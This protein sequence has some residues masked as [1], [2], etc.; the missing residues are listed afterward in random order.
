MTLAT[1]IVIITVIV[2]IGFVAYWIIT[3]FFTEPIKTPALV[4]VGLI[5]L[6][7]LL[8]QFFPG[9]GSFQVWR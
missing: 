4:V 8:S 6:L 5:L 3:K 2:I 7:V 1:A 9:L